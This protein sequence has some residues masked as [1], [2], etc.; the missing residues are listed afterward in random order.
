M[1]NVFIRAVREKTIE[2]SIEQK[3]IYG[4]V[5]NVCFSN[6]LNKNAE[7]GFSPDI[8]VLHLEI[9]NHKNGPFSTQTMLIKSHLWL[10]YQIAF[11]YVCE[12]NHMNYLLSLKRY[13]D[14]Q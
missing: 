6:Q 3:T 10:T 11:S 13:D 2:M 9:I 8:F 14:T 4:N 1:M 12:F 5:K 7:N